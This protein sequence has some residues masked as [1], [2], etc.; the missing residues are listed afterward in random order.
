ME[1]DAFGAD[2]DPA[3][4]WVMGWGNDPDS[5]H[6]RW[7]IDRLVD[8]G[9]RVHAATVPTNGTEFRADYVDPVRAYRREL[10]DHRIV[11]H[12]TGGLTVAHLRPSTPAVYLSP[13]WGV[14]GETP[15]LARL[16]F[17][18]PISTPILPAPVDPELL[19]GLATESDATAPER[20]SPAWMATMRSAQADLPPINPEDAVFYSPED[21]VVSPSTIEAHARQDQLHP[22]DG[23]HEFFASEDRDRIADRVVDAIDAAFADG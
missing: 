8:A 18:L 21:E 5:R 13:F 16:L 14:G 23:G 6:E 12:S 9:Y 11:S 2:D 4:L 7:F 19:G 20:L 22:Y 10:S 17:R 15:A 1:F 3:V